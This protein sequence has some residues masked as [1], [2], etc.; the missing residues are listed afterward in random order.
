LQKGKG[1]IL[2]RFKPDGDCFCSD[3]HKCVT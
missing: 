2:T 3:P 1:V